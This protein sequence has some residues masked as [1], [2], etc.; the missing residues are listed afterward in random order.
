MAKKV[1]NHPSLT[2]IENDLISNDSSVFTQ[3]LT[4]EIYVDGYQLG[5]NPSVYTP[6]KMGKVVKIPLPDKYGAFHDPEVRHLGNGYVVFG[7]SKRHK[8]MHKRCLNGNG[9]RLI[10]RYLG[11]TYNDGENHLTEDQLYQARKEF[12]W[13]AADTTIQEI[14]RSFQTISKSI[15]DHL[16][17]EFAKLTPF[18]NRLE[19]CTNLVF[20]IDPSELLEKFDYVLHSVLGYKVHKD[21]SEGC[22]VDPDQN[23]M[24]FC[25]TYII[26]IPELAQKQK[27]GIIK[28]KLYHKNNFVRLEIAFIKFNF[29]HFLDGNLMRF[30]S[31]FEALGE[32]F[33]AMKHRA[34]TLINMI[35]A[36][37]YAE[38]SSVDCQLLRNKITKIIKIDSTVLNSI[39]SDLAIKGIYWF[40][41][42][43]IPQSQRRKLYG[44]G[45]FT[46]Q[47]GPDNKHAIRLVAGWESIEPQPLKSDTLRSFSKKEVLAMKDVIIDAIDLILLNKIM[48]ISKIRFEP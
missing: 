4:P 16:N 23:G 9:S 33:M 17:I 39:V 43:R 21:T 8:G 41:D 22:N 31:K 14:V 1:S 26:H 5:L 44:S 7:S 19:F 46:K 27:S 12:D 42:K 29:V 20:P 36:H 2:P 40:N 24:N 32:A 15:A 45:I 37:L 47:K 38:H 25:R 35:V 13:P 48:T 6:N 28:I 18:A 10:K 11:I 30:E 34:E 3:H